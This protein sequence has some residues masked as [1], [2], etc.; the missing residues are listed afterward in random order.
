MDQPSKITRIIPRRGWGS[1]GLKDVWEFR[2]LLFF[3]VWREI[4]GRYRQMALGPLWIVLKPFITMVVMSVVF[5]RL[6]KLPSDGVPYP[7]FNYCA[8]LPWT[9]FS[10]SVS[11]S[12]TSL[13]SNMGVISKVYFPRLVV[14]LSSAC[15][16]LLDFCFSFLILLCMMLYFGYLPGWQV[17]FLPVYVLLAL[18]ASLALGLCLATAAVKFR[19]VGYAVDHLLQVAMYITPVV[20]P[21]SL[22]PEPWR[23]IYL[24]NPMAVVIEGFRWSLLGKG[25]APGVSLYLS[26]GLVLI[27]L[28]LGAHL[29]R[30]GERNVVDLL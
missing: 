26:A 14:P 28:F 20:Y 13:V 16:G 22:V 12:A 25:L 9:M 17:V 11:K 15:A 7:L 8:L 18:M 23:Q 6:A 4:K 10:V 27:T 29:F 19:D 1:L 3:L 21:S 5:G 30:R 24:L 2:E